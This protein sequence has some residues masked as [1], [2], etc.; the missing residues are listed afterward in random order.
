MSDGLAS[1]E[2][3]FEITE[4]FIPRTENV[5]DSVVRRKEIGFHLSSRTCHNDHDRRRKAHNCF[6]SES[7]QRTVML[8][9]VYSVST[10]NHMEKWILFFVFIV[11]VPWKL[12]LKTS[13]SKQAVKLFQASVFGEKVGFV[14]NTTSQRSQVQTVVFRIRK[15]THNL[16]VSIWN[17]WWEKS[18]PIPPTAN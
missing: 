8:S 18:L 5:M 14:L 10:E 7:Y 17:C 12:M 11:T 15:L 16:A 4:N 3:H 2:T 9:C 1:Y 13:K 6:V